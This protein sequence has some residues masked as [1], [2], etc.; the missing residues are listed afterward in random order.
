MGTTQVS[1]SQLSVEA[2]GAA[3]SRRSYLLTATLA[4]LFVANIFDP[5]GA[6]GLKYFAFL[7][8]ALSLFWT[9]KY[10]DLTLRALTVGL[11]LFVIWP[12]WSLLFGAARGGDMSVGLTQVTPFIFAVVLALILPALDARLPL[13]TFYACLVLLAVVVITSFALIFFLPDNAISQTVFG[14]LTSLQGKEGSFG[15]QSFDGLDVPWIYFT[16]TLFLV[17]AFVYY[18]FV[19][20]LFRAG[21]VL[22]ALGLTFSKAGLTIALVFGVA[23][24][25]FALFSR[26]AKAGRNGTETPFRRA[27][28]RFL[29]IAV[30]GGVTL[31]ILSSLPTFSE[32]IE[33]AWGGTSDTALV[34]IGHFHSVMH[35]FAEHPSYL[36]VGQGAGIAFF[37]LGESG[38]VQSFEIDHLNA[39]RKFGLPW[40]I[41]YSAIVFY[42]ARKLLMTGQTEDRAFGFALISA[43]VAAGTNPVLLSSLFVT[44]ITLSYFV[45]RSCSVS[46]D[47]QAERWHA[48]TESSPTGRREQ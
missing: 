34:R 6:L 4:L 33:D 9:L 7:V 20:K 44:M 23:Y 11:V 13:R 30:V 16:S 22:L 12:T 43:Y 2:S 24:S 5:L 19:A 27:C 1:R 15:T 48:V 31:L 39:I 32:E 28:R 26:S 46:S 42:S 3:A 18:L 21:I 8:A 47:T 10:F 29:P 45:Q 17:P 38:Y 40:L 41:G 25:L 36:I 37:S 14:Y 35:L